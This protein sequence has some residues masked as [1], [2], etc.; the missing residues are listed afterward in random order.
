MSHV[1]L[2]SHEMCQGGECTDASHGQVWTLGMRDLHTCKAQIRRE[3][4][5]NFSLHR[6]IPLILFEHTH[7]LSLTHTLSYVTILC[8]L[9]FGNEYYS[10]I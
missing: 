10:E 5:W 6:F 9:V 7:T 2:Q 8:S 4:V 3:L 1:K